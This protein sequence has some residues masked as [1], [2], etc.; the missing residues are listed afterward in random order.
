[1]NLEKITIDYIIVGTGSAGYVLANRL[2]VHD[3]SVL[4]IEAEF[5]TTRWALAK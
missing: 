2:S 4:F 3:H 1:M 5:F